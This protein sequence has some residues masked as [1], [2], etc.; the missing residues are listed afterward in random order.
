MSARRSSRT[1]RR[2]YR[3]C[4]EPSWRGLTGLDRSSRPPNGARMRSVDHRPRPVDPVGLPQPPPAGHPRPAA[5]L[6][7]QMLP[8]DPGMQH[9]QDL[10]RHLP[11]VDMLAHRKPVPAL[12]RRDQRLDHLRQLVADQLSRC[13]R[14]VLSGGGD[15]D[16]F[17]ATTQD[18]SLRCAL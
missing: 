14:T 5:H 8:R 13:L 3:W 11:I 12:D 9:E 7:G 18:T 16:P 4:L 15:A 6:L 2:R 10:R 17:A 1:Q